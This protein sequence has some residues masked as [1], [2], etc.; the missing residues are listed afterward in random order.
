MGL[1][2][3][4]TRATSN[5]QSSHMPKPAP[6]PV[7]FDGSHFA[8]VDAIA[9]GITPARLRA[10]D[11]TAPFRGV[12]TAD[13]LEIS[14]RSRLLAY[15]VHMADDEV[16]SH[17]TA[18][19][20]YGVPLPSELERMSTIHVS[21]QFPSHPPQVRGVSGHRLWVPIAPRTKDGFRMISPARTFTQLAALLAHDDLVVAGDY[22]V[23]RRN[24]LCSMVELAAA[25]ASMGAARGALAARL[26]LPEI[27]SGTDSPM[28]TRS[29]LLIVR[30][31]L[32]EPVIHYEVH[33][34]NGDFVGTPDLAYVKE[35]IAIE[36]QGSEHWTD[37]RVFAEDVE[38]RILFERAGWFVI[39]I[40]KNHIYT[41]PHWTAERIREAL[42]DRANLQP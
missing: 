7:G 11:L 17:I 5:G 41:N 31:G 6:L 12:R 15:R 34:Q 39:L 42:R 24:P 36:Y 19:Q 18:A 13:S 14:L 1:W 2:I 38:R 21:V 23:R 27:R 32:P 28:E 4:R 9:A 3:I 37:P 30:A 26:A 40:L 22:L 16:F 29:R 8:T 10:S 25:V 33:D 35:R 20:L